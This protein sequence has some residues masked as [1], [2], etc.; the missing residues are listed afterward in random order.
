MRRSE[1]DTEGEQENQEKEVTQTG[2][3]EDQ[4]QTTEINKGSEAPNSLDG[5]QEPKTADIAAEND[6]PQGASKF[7]EEI[8]DPTSKVEQIDFDDRNLS[9]TSEP[10][11]SLNERSSKQESQRDN[12]SGDSV[13]QEPAPGQPQTQPGEEDPA[14][15]GESGVNA[16]SPPQSERH[17]DNQENYRGGGDY[18]DSYGYSYFPNYHMQPPGITKFYVGRILTDTTEDQIRQTFTP[19]GDVFDVRIIKKA[20]NG[21]PLRETYYAFVLISLHKTVK[22]VTSHFEKNPT[23]KGWNVS[24]AKESSRNDDYHGYRE[25]SPTR[26]RRGDFGSP[27]QTPGGEPS[28]FSQGSPSLPPGQFAGRGGRGMSSAERNLSSGPGPNKF[29]RDRWNDGRPDHY[30]RD[31]W[32]PNGGSSC[33]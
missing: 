25:G 9:N 4:Q 27:A 20:Y 14:N 7:Q 11:H 28:T 2:D 24:L 12:N 30:P 29:Y 21:Q 33:A 19:F 13:N 32:D 5:I 6:P 22:E 18:S 8:Q 31:N 26:K 16:S 15:P 17:T 1:K 10:P 23:K 3:T